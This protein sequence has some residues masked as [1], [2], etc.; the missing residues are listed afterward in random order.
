MET[1]YT[2][3]R[4]KWRDFLADNYKTL[5]EIWFVFR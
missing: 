2:D 5:S 3:K 4:S 1:F